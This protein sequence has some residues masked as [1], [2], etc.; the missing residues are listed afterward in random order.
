MSN[1]GPAHPIRQHRLILVLDVGSVRQPRPIPTA[2]FYEHSGGGAGRREAVRGHRAC[3]LGGRTRVVGAAEDGQGDGRSPRVS[4]RRAPS[5][6][7]GAAQIALGTRMSSLSFLISRIIARAIICVQISSSPSLF[8][9]SGYPRSQSSCQ[10]N[11]LA[12]LHVAHC[13]R[14]VRATW[15]PI[16]SH[17]YAPGCRGYRWARSLTDTLSR[18]LMH[19]LPGR[20]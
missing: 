12:V 15:A 3:H 1:T 16:T 7:Q 20:N 9:A 18:A 11:H 6:L 17:F 13:P 19:D 4:L 2:L 5:A 8:C 14:P 10:I